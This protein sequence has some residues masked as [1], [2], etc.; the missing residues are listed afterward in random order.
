MVRFRAVLFDAAG[1]LI[2]LR[3][4]VGETYRRLALSYGVTLPAARIEE[5]FRR[6]LRQAPPMVWPGKPPAQGAELERRWWH[7]VV[8]SSFRAADASARFTD[9]E[10]YFSTLFGHFARPEA[11]DSAPGAMEALCA[12]RA[13]GIRTGVVSNFDHR[14]AGLLEGLGLAP[15]IEVVI[16]PAD[17]H[18]A[19]PDPRI[20]GCA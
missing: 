13:S 17:A 8:R 9:F 18:A 19:K 12:L 3:E 2:R 4:P 15:Q 16:R 7:A 1:T 5:A 20:F 6:V 10:G 11:W 14:L